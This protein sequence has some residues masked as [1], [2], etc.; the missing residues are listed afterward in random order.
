ML[1]YI[2]GGRRFAKPFHPIR[3]YSM[4]YLATRLRVVTNQSEGSF[5]L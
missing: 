1:A 5:Y 2:S 4:L 3:K